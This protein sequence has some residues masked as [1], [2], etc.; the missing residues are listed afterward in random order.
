MRHQ[1]IN[2]TLSHHAGAVAI[3]AALAF[4]TGC[5]AADTGTPVPTTAPTAAASPAATTTV[6]GAVPITITRT[7][8]FAGV[9]DT[10]TIDPSG[11][12]TSQSRS[13]TDATGQ[14]S[15]SALDQLRT[16]AADPHVAVEA[17]APTQP[18]QCADGFHY[19]VG[20]DTA[21]IRFE[22]CAHSS[23]PRVAKAILGVVMGAVPGW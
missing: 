14:L 15:A 16:L 5:D 10:L 18:A 7:G 13:S 3:V 17:A 4:L 20:V 9:R 21:V 12:W 22:D 2:K 19:T 6:K 8:G 23:E 11:A 1:L